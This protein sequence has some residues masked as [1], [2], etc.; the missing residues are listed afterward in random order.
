METQSTT[1]ALSIEESTNL[2]K[3]TYDAFFRGDIDGLLELYTDDI[4]WQVF[5]P[6][7]LPTAGPHRGKEEVRAFFGKVNDLLESDKFEVQ[8]YVAQGNTVV[9][10]GEF[11]WTSKVTGRDFDANFVHIVTIR[12]GKICKF[13]EYSDTATAIAA[14]VD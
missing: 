5:G 9:A 12:D 10:H 14:M 7:I 2:V 1:G 13:R 3:Q 8:H 11:A 4:D 6:S